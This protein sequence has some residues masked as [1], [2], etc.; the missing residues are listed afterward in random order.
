MWQAICKALG[1]QLWVKQYP[2]TQ[3]V[4]GQVEKTD[5]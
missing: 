4:P 3:G 2:G 1:I 5:S